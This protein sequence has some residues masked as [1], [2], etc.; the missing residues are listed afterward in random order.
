MWFGDVCTV[1][2]DDMWSVPRDSTTFWALWWHVSLLRT[3]FTIAATKFTIWLVNLPLLMSPDNAAH[4]NVSDNAS[5]S[6]RSE[7]TFL[8][9]WYWGNKQIKMCFSLVCTLIDNNVSHHSGQSV[10]VDSR[11]PAEWVHNTFNMLNLIFGIV[12]I[13]YWAMELYSNCP[14]IAH[15]SCYKWNKHQIPCTCKENQWEH[16]KQCVTA[17][18]VQTG[19]HGNLSGDITVDCASSCSCFGC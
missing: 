16:F 1:I 2:N 6:L 18:P 13:L 4:I 11:C 8:W 12:N 19:W 15:N 5:L 9:C 10:V 3:A 7:K 14:I 17:H